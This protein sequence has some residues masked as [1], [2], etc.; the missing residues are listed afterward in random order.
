MAEKQSTET[1]I[2]RIF[3]KLD[4]LEKGMSDVKNILRADYITRNEFQPLKE[5]VGS[6][7]KGIVGILTFIVIS[8]V[9]AWLS[10]LIR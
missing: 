9:G 2:A 6:I 5:E 10:G 4:N 7:K 8:L 3:D 1:K